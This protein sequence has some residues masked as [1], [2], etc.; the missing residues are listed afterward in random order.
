MV[1]S[2]LVVNHY[3]L[4]NLNYVDPLLH[5]RVISTLAS[6]KFEFRQ[7]QRNL[8]TTGSEF[9]IEECSRVYKFFGG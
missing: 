6:N 9:M 7:V 2:F 4:V 1:S 5:L 3:F 8:L